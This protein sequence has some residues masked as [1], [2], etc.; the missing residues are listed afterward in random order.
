MFSDKRIVGTD[1]DGTYQNT[2][3]VPA[4]SESGTWTVEYAV[5]RDAAGNSRV[6]TATNLANAGIPNS[7]TN[8]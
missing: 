2:M 8:N 1:L 3:V 4:F 6:L 7:F 5:L